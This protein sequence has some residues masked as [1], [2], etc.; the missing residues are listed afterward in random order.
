VLSQHGA[1]L[2]RLAGALHGLAGQLRRG[3]QLLFQVS[4]VGDDDDFEGPQQRVGAH[5][6]N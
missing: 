4:A 3:G 5:G 6:A 2:G 1:Q